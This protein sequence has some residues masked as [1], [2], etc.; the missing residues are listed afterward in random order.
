MYI[1]TSVVNFSV[2]VVTMLISW[3]MSS[4]LVVG[5]PPNFSNSSCSEFSGIFVAL[6]SVRT[7]TRS[8]DILFSDS[9]YF[10]MEDNSETGERSSFCCFTTEVRARETKL[11]T[12]EDFILSVWCLFV[13]ETL[14]ELRDIVT[15]LCDLGWGVTWA[16]GVNTAG[17]CVQSPPFLEQSCYM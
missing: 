17:W 5:L 10:P 11:G 13:T 3:T 16:G 4:Q 8:L 2:S 15:A 6:R 1:I 9:S 14:I 12:L 7:F